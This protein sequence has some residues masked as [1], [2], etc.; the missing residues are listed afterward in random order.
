MRLLRRVWRH[1][2]LITSLVR[3]QYQLRYR[4]SAVGFAWALLPPLAAVGVGNLLFK[5]VVHVDTGRAS[6]GLFA[7][8]ALIPWTLFANSLILGV[9]SVVGA[10]SM[11]TRL[12]FPRAALPLSMAGLS[13]ID[14]A[15]TMVAFVALAFIQGVGVPV[16][17]LWV[18]V[19][20]LV[21]LPLIVGIVLFGSA[22]NV[23]ARDIRLAVPLLVQFWLF[24]TPVMYPLRAVP[25]SLRSTYLVNPMTGL[26]ESF[27]QVL[28]A[29]HAPSVSLLLPAIVGA[30]VALVVGVWYFGSTEARFADVI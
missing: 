13:L 5:H 6:Y 26:V 7:L 17:A 29:G 20:L 24:L 14:L 1:R 2:A 27:R 3:R 19:L 12:A 18:P 10:S 16:T 15:L 21:E 22:L 4:Q 30:V 8:A 9:P 28:V 23:F 11:I 25:A